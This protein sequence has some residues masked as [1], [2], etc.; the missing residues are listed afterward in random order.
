MRYVV[1]RRNAL[2]RLEWLDESSTLNGALRKVKEINRNR[3]RCYKAYPAYIYDTVEECIYRQ[4]TTRGYFCVFVGGSSYSIGNPEYF[5]SIEAIKNAL[6]RR[7][8]DQRMY[9]CLDND[10]YFECYSGAMSDCP[11]FMIKVG[12]RGGIFKESC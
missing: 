2:G 8:N 4:D 9:P 5:R 3:E 1:Q 7:L 10:A 12:P 6:W 11:D